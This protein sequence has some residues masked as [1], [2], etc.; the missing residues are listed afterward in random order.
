MHNS[1]K[2]FFSKCVPIKWNRLYFY[3]IIQILNLSI[4]KCML[5]K[6]DYVER[7]NIFEE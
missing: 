2:I 6:I 7:D 1:A 4:A 3:S 5:D